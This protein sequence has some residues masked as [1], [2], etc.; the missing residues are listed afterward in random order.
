MIKMTLLLPSLRP[1]R[2]P[3]PSH[4]TETTILFLADSDFRK[5]STPLCMIPLT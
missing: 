2:A 5:K 3:L 4:L 1:L